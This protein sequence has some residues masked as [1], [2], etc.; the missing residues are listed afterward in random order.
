MSIT[1]AKQ[2][3]IVFITISFSALFFNLLLAQ[4]NTD[5]IDAF[6]LNGINDTALNSKDYKL[7]SGDNY[8]KQYMNSLG[9]SFFD[10]DRDGGI[11][12]LILALNY[13]EFLKTKDLFDERFGENIIV[14][15]KTST[16]YHYVG[17]QYTVGVM[18]QNAGYGVKY[19]ALIG[20]N[21]SLR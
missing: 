11:D 19:F 21:A 12:L 8:Q 14:T 2:V 20:H 1:P 15:K 18:K 3:L 16:T 7:V 13:D 9:D 6:A 17:K 5:A 10:Y 4:T